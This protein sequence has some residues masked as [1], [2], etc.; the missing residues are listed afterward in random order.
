MVT[1]PHGLVGGL[2][3][4]AK[5][6]SHLIFVNKTKSSKLYHYVQLCLSHMQCWMCPTGGEVRQE[7]SQNCVGSGR[8]GSQY[9]HDVEY[10]A[11]HVC[12][13]LA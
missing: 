8:E 4:F 13:V 1:E 6:M 12:L 2:Q 3:L 9:H 11:D 7:N 5:M 10:G